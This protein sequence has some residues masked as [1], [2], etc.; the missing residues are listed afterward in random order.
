MSTHG[1]A[2]TR[3]N[4][5]LRRTPAIRHPANETLAARS[6]PP[7]RKSLRGLSIRISCCTQE[8]QDGDL[9]IHRAGNFSCRRRI[10]RFGA[11]IR[12]ASWQARQREERQR[13]GDLT[14]RFRG[15]HTV[16]A[17]KTLE[18]RCVG[19]GRLHGR[20][21]LNPARSMAFSMPTG[22]ARRMP[23]PWSVNTRKPSASAGTGRVAP[24]LEIGW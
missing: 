8:R 22:A 3:S 24:V 2:R 16:R 15:K 4:I 10:G 5:S 6:R 11:V 7:G 21:C 14:A 20:R 13:A 18:C 19:S 17:K 23:W 1:H 9:R 12:K